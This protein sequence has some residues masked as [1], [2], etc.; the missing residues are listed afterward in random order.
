MK[1][2][3]QTIVESIGRNNGVVILVYW[4]DTEKKQGHLLHNDDFMT[5]VRYMAVGILKKESPANKREATSIFPVEK[6]EVATVTE[7]GLDWESSL[8][9]HPK[10]NCETYPSNSGLNH[11][12]KSAVRPAAVAEIIVGEI[13]IREWLKHHEYFAPFAKQWFFEIMQRAHQ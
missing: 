10:D 2:R 4:C 9:T 6:F 1:A 12:D 3:V 8:D 5:E 11:E 13:A 7:M